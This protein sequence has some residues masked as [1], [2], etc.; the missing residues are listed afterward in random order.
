MSSV[1]PTDRHVTPLDP[2]N[3][4][5]NL[6]SAAHA[7]IEMFRTPAFKCNSNL[8]ILLGHVD[9]DKSLHCVK[10]HSIFV[11]LNIYLYLYNSNFALCLFFCL[12]SFDVNVTSMEPAV[13][14]ACTSGCDAWIQRQIELKAGVD[15]LGQVR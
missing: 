6:S 13:G 7:A 11:C 12:S 8:V 3:Q 5:H 15:C 1:D 2:H 10:R 4:P 9:V 14:R